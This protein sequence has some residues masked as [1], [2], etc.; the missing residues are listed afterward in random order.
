MAIKERLADMWLGFTESVVLSI[1]WEVIWVIVFAWFLA[2]FMAFPV[3]GLITTF[4]WPSVGY[5]GA[6]YVT[7]TITT[8]ICIVIWV[9]DLASAVRL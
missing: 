8:G 4:L 6:W 5:L 9:V 1:L 2:A 7:A 3:W